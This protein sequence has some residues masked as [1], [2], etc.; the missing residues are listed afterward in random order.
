M[1]LFTQETFNVPLLMTKLLAEAPLIPFLI[2]PLTTS[3]PV[4]LMVRLEPDLNFIPA[5]S[6]SEAVSFVSLSIMVFF[7]SKIKFTSQLFFITKGP[8]SELSI[9][10]ELKVI[11][12][13]SPFFTSIP[14][15]EQEPLIK[16]SSLDN[17]VT[18]LLL[19]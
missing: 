14:H 13:E 1:A 7:P 5:P 9:D 19:I 10:I 17:R 2:F 16:Y 15:S 8:V 11:V 6:K 4:P 12:G 3:I 18:M